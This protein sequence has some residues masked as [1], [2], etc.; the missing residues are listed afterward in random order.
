MVE[1]MQQSS[2]RQDLSE[3]MDH[4]G[5]RAR[6]AAKILAYA[7]TDTKNTAI[8]KTAHALR[9]NCEEIL[10]ANAEDVAEAQAKKLPES[11]IDRMM[12]NEKKIFALSDSLLEIVELPD[13]VGKIL[14]SVNRPNGLEISKISTPLGVI[15]M[16]YESRPNVTADAGA[17]AIKSGNAVILR[18]G[19]ECVRSNRA[20]YACL[21]EG[22]LGAG[23]PIES[24]M[25]VPV[26]D[27]KAVGYMLAEMGRYIDV[28][29]PRGGK[30]LVDRV[31]KEA[32][33]P[34][35][36]H[37]EGICHTYVDGDANLQMAI[38]LVMNAKMRR[39]GVCGATE[40]LLI[41]G[42]V[43]HYALPIL[44]ALSDAGCEIRGDAA[45]CAIFP[46][47]ISATEED[48]KTEYLDKIIS[49]RFVEGVDGAIQHIDQYGSG[50]TEC[51][52]TENSET[53][54]RFLREIDAAIVTVNAST[55]FADGGEFGMGAEIGIATGRIHARGPVGLEQLTLF[56]YR[57]IGSGQIRPL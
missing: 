5:K 18:G 10:E 23:L 9:E 52:V 13:P 48:W 21:Q 28:I 26:Q 41:D 43:T 44:N 25:L 51:I 20:I 11:S 40:T 22:A 16:I 30:S 27:R 54:S 55:Q 32:R 42:N 57:V 45:V 8:R 47:A 50:H 56:K 29:I 34:V 37:L 24:V 17:L 19:S 49:V 3:L 12:L 14:Q 31:Q 4:I 46:K 38:N 2:D 7:S 1:E 35:L 53:A 33:I 15:G 6:A 39:T 36:A